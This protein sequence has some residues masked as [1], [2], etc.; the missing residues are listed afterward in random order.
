MKTVPQQSY[1][2]D[3]FASLFDVED[4]HFWFR[5]RNK[6]IAAL[7]SQVAARMTAGYRVLEA[8]CGTG[9]VLR[10]LERTCP[11][12]MVVGM[13]LSPAGLQ[14]A[15]QR[16]SCSLVH[17]CCHPPCYCESGDH[18]RRRAIVGSNSL[19]IRSI[20]PWSINMGTP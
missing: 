12:G 14:Y 15:R 2:P 6:A 4:R 1:D 20:E 16:T 10:V 3:S 9:N 8:G 11:G 13:D 18:Y 7:T 5:A 19:V 17:A